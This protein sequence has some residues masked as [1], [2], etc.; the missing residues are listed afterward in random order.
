VATLAELKA[1]IRLETNKDDISS[2]GEAVAAL[3]TAIERAIDHYAEEPFWFN[4]AGIVTP[5]ATDGASNIWT[6]EA[7]DLIAARVRM[8]LYR[9][10]WQ[11]AENM[12]LAGQAEA[13]AFRVLMRKSARRADAPLTTGIPP[14]C[15][16][17]DIS[18][19]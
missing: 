10:L 5:P 16:S 3:T 7:E 8:L 15:S 14:S 12:A 11:D 9:D 19:G 13:E 2:D 18:N 6:S 4:T 17:F 1:R